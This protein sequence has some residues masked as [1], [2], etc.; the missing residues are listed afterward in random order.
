[1]TRAATPLLHVRT[2]SHEQQTCAG[3]AGFLPEY[4]ENLQAFAHITV[5]SLVF[6]MRTGRIITRADCYVW[7]DR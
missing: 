3:T 6:P 7:T 1:M 2:E 4:T 5:N